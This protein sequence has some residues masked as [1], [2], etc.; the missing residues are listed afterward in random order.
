MGKK[1]KCPQTCDEQCEHFCYIGEGDTMCDKTIP[2]K[3]ILDD[4][5]PTDDY[6]WCMGGHE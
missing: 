4:W 3:I 6:F 1:K 5:T 2:P